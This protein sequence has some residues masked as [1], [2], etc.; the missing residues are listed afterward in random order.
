MS[1][2]YLTCENTVNVG[3]SNPP[4]NRR[5]ARASRLRWMTTR[6]VAA[7]HGTEMSGVAWETQELVPGL[8]GPDGQADGEVSLAGAGR[9]GD[10]LQH[11]R[12]MLP[13][14]VRVTGEAHPLFGRLV[15]AASFKRWN[16]GRFQSVM[17]T[18][19]SAISGRF[20]RSRQRRGFGRLRL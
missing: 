12:A 1:T 20:I 7:K 14:E 6:A 2:H 13:C 9:E 3:L 19:C 5:S 15:K 17:A 4:N 8:A 16:G 18:Q 10:K 11:L